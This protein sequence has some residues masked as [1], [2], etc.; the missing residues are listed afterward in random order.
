MTGEQLETI[1][2]A[3]QLA[4]AEKDGFASL[5]DGTTLTLYVARDGGTLTIARVDG[6]RLEG[7]LVYAR[8]SKRET[9]YIVVRSDVFA[10]SIDGAVGQ[11]ARRAG[12]A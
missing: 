10:A 5:P 7:E 1:L 11:P 3:A 8:T 12:F 6:V 4:K 2:K 9:T